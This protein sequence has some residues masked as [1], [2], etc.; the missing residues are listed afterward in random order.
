ML[1]G[2]GGDR[3]RAKRPVMGSI[4]AKYADRIIVTSD[5]PRNENRMAI[6]EDILKGIPKTAE[7]T[8]IPD[9]C[10]AIAYAVRSAR[11]GEVLLL[12]GKGAERY[13]TVC[14]KKIPFSEK[15]ILA[16][17]AKSNFDK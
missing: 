6:I 15:E 14:G 7:Y 5:N 3:D 8:V 9:R 11:R 16:E 17:A 2:C 1:F 12:S 4:A 10:E 13:E